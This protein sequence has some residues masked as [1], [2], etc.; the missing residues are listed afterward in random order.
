[1]RK[2]NGLERKYLR[3]LAHHLKPFVLV[4]KEGVTDRLVAT[5]MRTFEKHELI[6]IKFLEFKKEKEILAGEIARRSGSQE[7]G[8]IGHVITFYRK[9]PEE[10]KR[11]IQFP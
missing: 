8:T 11:N 9:N 5:I 3:S 10:E 6:K 4:G 1:M 2:L 7:V